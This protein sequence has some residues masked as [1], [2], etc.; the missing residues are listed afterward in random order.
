MRALVA[1]SLA[2]AV[3]TAG[4]RTSA[5]DND[6]TTLLRQGVELRREHR[7]EAAL[8]IFARAFAIGGSPTARAQVALAEQALGRWIDAERD[9][10]AALGTTDDPWI[11]KNRATLEQARTEIEGHLAW[12]TV[13]LNATNADI[14]MGSQTIPPATDARVPA[15]TGVLEVHAAGYVFDHRRVE[16]TPGEHLRIAVT[17]SPVRAQQPP[18]IPL[19]AS[20]KPEAAPG[21]HT[22]A[23]Y[24]SRIGPAVLGVLGLANVGVGIYFGVHALDERKLRD[25]GCRAGVCTLDALSNDAEARK[26]A[27]LSTTAVCAGVAFLSAG[28]TWWG[29]DWRLAERGTPG[30]PAASAGPLVLVALGLAAAGAGTSL[31]LHA[32]AEKRARDA[33]CTSAACS[34]AALDYDTEARTS[35]M[36]STVSFGSA[37]ALFSGALALWGSHRAGSRPGWRIVPGLGSQSVALSIDGQIE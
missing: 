20:S 3:L 21:R 2:A 24:E 28:A 1:L 18:S 17:L 15:G 23:S 33:L 5:D 9:L 16:L 36:L 7:N 14:Q 4:A 35:A 6:A 22:L 27:M 37:V 19:R 13:T 26:A 32:L 30:R 10:D 29:A 8:D 34:P 25:A 11:A 31:G 12:L